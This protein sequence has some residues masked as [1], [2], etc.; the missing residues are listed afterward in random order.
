MKVQS[1]NV[2]TPI[3]FLDLIWKSVFITCNTWKVKRQW[4]VS[5]T[6]DSVHFHTTAINKIRRWLTAQINTEQHYPA[7]TVT[8]M[9]SSVH[10]CNW[11]RLV[12]KHFYNHKILNGAKCALVFFSI[13]GQWFSLSLA[14]YVLLLHAVWITQLKRQ[15][16]NSVLA[17]NW[18]PIPRSSSP[19]T[20]HCC[21]KED[22]NN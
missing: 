17:R 4:C 13:Y 6:H 16:W 10:K 20:S 22:V 3:R 18:N 12:F 15:F 21:F 1:C 2:K 5:G 8:S 11:C 9:S 14:M 19:W 7:L